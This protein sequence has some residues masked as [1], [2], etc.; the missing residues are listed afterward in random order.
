M[1][2]KARAYAEQARAYAEQARAYAEQARADFDAYVAS[3]ESPQ[4]VIGEHHR[5]Q[6]L[7]MAL[8]KMAKAFLY[9]AEPDARYPHAVALAA[10][11]RLRQHAVSE[12]VGMTMVTFTRSLNAARPILL[13]IEAASPSVGFDDRTLDRDESERTANVEYPWQ[14]DVNDPSSWVAPAG[15]PLAVM[16]NLRRDPRSVAAVR[17]LGRLIAAA[18]AV[19]P[20]P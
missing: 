4:P 14:S 2:S 19:L 9:S 7:Q 5:L 1:A 11:N 17:L 8:E 18:G 3:G 16:Q 6:L 12:A 20:Q 13:Q 15:R 10:V